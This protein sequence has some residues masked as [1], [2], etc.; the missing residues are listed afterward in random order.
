MEAGYFIIAI[1]GCADSSATCTP[2]ATVPTHFA[3]EAACSAATSQALVENSD[4][5]FPRLLA[6]C[7]PVAP[8]SAAAGEPARPVPAGALSS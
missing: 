5:E 4:L 6:E 7:R 1:L 2:V 8:R 3:S